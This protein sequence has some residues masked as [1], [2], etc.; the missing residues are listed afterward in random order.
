VKRLG[1]IAFVVGC[2][3]QGTAP[4]TPADGSSTPVVDASVPD[5][6]MTAPPIDAPPPPCFNTG[7]LGKLC[8]SATPIDVTLSSPI[9]TSDAKVCTQTATQ[10]GSAPDLCVIA[11]KTITVQGNV[12]A[13][14]NRALVLVA[15]ETLTVAAGATLDASSTTAN[16]RRTGAGANQ[17]TC[18]PPSKP[19]DSGQGAGAAGGGS[20]ATQGSD[21]GDGNTN[22]GTAQGGNAGKAQAAPT[23]LRGG[24]AGGRGGSSFVV[25]NGGTGGDGGGALYL[26]AG[27]SIA[28][29]G[30][31][32]ASG[33]GGDGGGAQSGGGGGG[34][35]GM[36]GLDAP[37]VASGA[38]IT[39]NGR[40]VA[41]GGAGASGGGGMG[42][43]NPGKDGTTTT[44]N[45]AAAGGGGGGTGGGGGPGTAVNSANPA[46]GG[47]SNNGGGGGGGGLGIVTIYGTVAGGTTGKTISPAPTTH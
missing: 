45:T 16:P 32:F 2:S 14:G 18:D 5:D 40:V 28:I 39:I 6:A 13:T 17:G 10:S 37:V 3:F 25:A 44:W 38:S 26:I 43:G 42:A 29:T 30:D 22:G 21:G 23:V 15:V 12:T 9:N 31:V 8:L 36:I 27:T 7:L 35:G 4:S 19:Q 33:A 11:G 20:L 46:N 41:N 47:N 24:C 34:T 1:W